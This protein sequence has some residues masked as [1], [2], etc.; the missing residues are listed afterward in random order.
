MSAIRTGWG[1][2]MKICIKPILV[3]GALV[4]GLAAAASA[5]DTDPGVETGDTEERVVERLGKP[6]GV[7][8]RGDRKLY[9]YEQGTVQIVTGRV[10]KALLVSRE[11]AHERTLR[12]EQE[13]R[14]RRQQEEAEQR[15]VTEAGAAELARMLADKAFAA[16]PAAE[17]VDYWNQFA[18]RYPYTDVTAPMT[19][20][21]S[22]LQSQQNKASQMTELVALMKRTGEIG[23]RLKQLE[24]DYAASLAN[25]KRN[26]IDAE[27]ARLN[28]EL[29]RIE[30]R[31]RE[32]GGAR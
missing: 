21:A 9:Y 14:Q 25:W 3:S 22:D 30:V 26:E 19:L 8:T 10:V 2:G 20:A 18:K 13:E 23:E 16:R 5:G 29:A 27:R 31:V 32:L 17:R 7:I 6:Q 1:Q 28:E 24:A 4:A 11:E 15:R 12:R